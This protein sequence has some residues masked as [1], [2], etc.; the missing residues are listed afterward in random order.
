MQVVNLSETTRMHPHF[1]RMGC[2]LGLGT[3]KI[4]GEEVRF[5]SNISLLSHHLQFP[6]ARRCDSPRCALFLLKFGSLNHVSP[7]NCSCSFQFVCQRS[8]MVSTPIV[9]AVDLVSNP[10]PRPVDGSLPASALTRHILIRYHSDTWNAKPVRWET[11]P[12]A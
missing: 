7:R 9:P 3:L 1:K 10:P 12:S 6:I 11:R 2:V 5:M 4:H 8:Q